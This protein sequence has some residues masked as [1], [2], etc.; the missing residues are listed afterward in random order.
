MAL[1]PGVK[2]QPPAEKLVVPRVIGSESSD[3]VRPVIVADAIVG[4]LST[5]TKG[6]VALGL[7]CPAEL[8]PKALFTRRD[9]VRSTASYARTGFTRLGPGSMPLKAVPS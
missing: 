4:R 6:G 7:F 5:T 1:Q 2:D 3:M 9:P 8:S